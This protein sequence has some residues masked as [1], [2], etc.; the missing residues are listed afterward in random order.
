MTLQEYTYKLKQDFAFYG[1]TETPLTDEQIE[2]LFDNGFSIDDAYSV[3]CDAFCGFDYTSSI[4][5]VANPQD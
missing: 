1:F 4:E 2:H 3:G 5:A